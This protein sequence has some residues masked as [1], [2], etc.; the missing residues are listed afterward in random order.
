[1]ECELG[2]R[3][4]ETA[5]IATTRPFERPPFSARGSKTWRTGSVQRG[6]RQG[7]LQRET[8]ARLNK[9]VLAS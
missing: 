9:T 2:L 8:H 4:R 5:T 3:S 1:M 6:E 7:A